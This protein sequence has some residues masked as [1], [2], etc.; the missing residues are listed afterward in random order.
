MVTN[1]EKSEIIEIRHVYDMSMPREMNLRWDLE[2]ILKIFQ[3]IFFS[4]S[5]QN[6][7]KW[8]EK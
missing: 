8:R 2:K 6:G 4:K 3:K 7:P 1:S 5:A